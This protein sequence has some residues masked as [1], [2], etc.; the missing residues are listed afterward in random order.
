MRIVRVVLRL[1]SLSSASLHPRPLRRIRP[2]AAMLT[3]ALAANG[4]AALTAD[5]EDVG[6]GLPPGSAVAD[7]F[8]FTSGGAHFNDQFADFGGGYTT[9]A[10]FAYSNVRNSVTPGYANQFAA[11]RPGDPLAGG[12][13]AVGYVDTYGPFIPRIT[14]ASDVHAVSLKVANTTY[15]ALSMR[16]GDAFS[17]KFGGA[18]GH[19]PDYFRLA[20]RG[21]D[22]A[23]GETGSVEFYLADYRFEDDALDAIVSGFTT[24]DL[25]SL[26]ALRAIE[27][28]LASSDTGAFGMNTPAFFAID[29]VVAAPE[30][31]SAVTVAAG[32]AALAAARRRRPGRAAA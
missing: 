17:K 20:I 28:T 31:A 23:G 21:L 10:G 3:V 12:T 27:F 30:P 8:G 9:W 1:L 26:G 7:S 2:Y 11:Y 25:S 18:T 22:A 4:A 13:Y 24:V 15:A 6:A 5:F 19:D 16:D 29:D 32:L 14:F